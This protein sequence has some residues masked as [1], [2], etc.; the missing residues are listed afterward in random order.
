MRLITLAVGIACLSRSQAFMPPALLQLQRARPS[1]L[2][3]SV[4]Q[5]LLQKSWRARPMQITMSAEAVQIQDGQLEK[6]NLSFS[7][8]LRMLEE[9]QS[10]KESLSGF[11]SNVA[12]VYEIGSK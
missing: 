7:Q 9:G 5:V 11:V 1:P 12:D 8:G 6:I 3:R 2:A 10:I 4:S